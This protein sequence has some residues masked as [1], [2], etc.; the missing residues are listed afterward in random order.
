MQ[1]WKSKSDLFD[2]ETLELIREVVE[3]RFA[4]LLLVLLR[5]VLALTCLLFLH[6]PCPQ[7]Q[8]IDFS[9]M[10]GSSEDGGHVLRGRREGGV[11][12]NVARLM[13]GM[14]LGQVERSRGGF[15][16]E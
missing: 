10:R 4:L 2:N 13:R 5:L 16:K 6:C 1:W 15:E 7:R 14:G 9:G 12:V 11:T 8:R 3:A